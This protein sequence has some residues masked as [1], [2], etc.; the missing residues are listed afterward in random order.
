MCRAIAINPLEGLK[1]TNIVPLLSTT[2]IHTYIHR[3]SWVHN[4]VDVCLYVGEIFAHQAIRLTFCYMILL[5]VR[6][7]HEAEPVFNYYRRE[8]HQFDAQVYNK[9]LFGWGQ[10]VSSDCYVKSWALDKTGFGSLHGCTKL[11]GVMNVTKL[12]FTHEV[13]AYPSRSN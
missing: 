1:G 9:L 7:V 4:E 10:K 12:C 13:M 6:K 8:G 5:L 2:Y 11:V 3:P